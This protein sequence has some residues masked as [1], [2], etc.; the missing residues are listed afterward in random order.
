MQ[1]DLD[2][3][4]SRVGAQ[5]SAQEQD[6]V[7]C[8]WPSC[9]ELIPRG[10]SRRCAVH[11][12]I[13]PYEEVARRRAHPRNLV[14]KDPRWRTCRRLVFERDNWT[15][16]DCGLVYDPTGRSLICDHVNEGGV[17]ACPDP[18]EPDFCATKCY[19]CS[20]RKDGARGNRRSA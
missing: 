6:L 7:L 19:R 9:P 12:N 10:G 13:L 15:C 2:F 16:T 5:A 14:Y 3:G 18:F 20:G 1:A 11:R 8:S 17:M 4:P